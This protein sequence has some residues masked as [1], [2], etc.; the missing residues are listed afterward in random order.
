MQDR[1]VPHCTQGQIW[2]EYCQRVMRD[3]TEIP[4]EYRRHNAM[5]RVMRAILEFRPPYPCDT[6]TIF[7]LRYGWDTQTIFQYR[8]V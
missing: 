4:L 5:G 3:D 7:S 6:R 8:H 2:F 1:R